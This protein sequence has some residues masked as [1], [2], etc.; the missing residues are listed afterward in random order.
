[1]KRISAFF[2]IIAIISSCN[3]KQEKAAQKGESL[4]QEYLLKGKEI[5]NLSQSEL[6]KNV[7]NAMKTGGPGHAVEFCNLRALSINDSLSRLHNCEIR[8]IATKYRN[9]EDMPQTKT[10]KD[11]LDEY[12]LAYQ[13]GDSIIPKVYHFDDRIEYYQPIFLSK[14]ACLLCHGVVGTQIAE[15]TLEEIQARYPNDLATGFA[16][17]EFRGAWKITF[18]KEIENQ[19]TKKPNVLF[20]AVDDLRPEL[21]FYG[22]S[23]IKSPNL[24]KLAASGVVFNKAYCNVPVCGASRS[25]LLTGI[26]PTYNRFLQYYAQAD[27]E[28]PNAITLP[29]HFKNNGYKTISVGKIFHT[30]MDN[31]GK[32]WSEMPYRFDHH[33]MPDGTWSDKGWQNYILEKNQKLSNE[34]GAGPAFEKGEVSDTAY[35]DGKY[36]TKAIEYLRQLKDDDQPFFMGLGF[37]KPHLPFNAPKR[38]WDMYDRDSIELADNPYFPESAPDNARFNWGELRAYHGIPKQGLLN[39][40]LSRTLAH[41]YYACVSATDALIGKVLNELDELGLRENTIVVLWGDHG[42][43]IGEHGMWCK[44]VNFETSLRTTL[45][46]SAPNYMTG[47]ANGI[48]ELVD[49][50]PTLTDLCAL[51]KLENQLQGQSLV[52]VLKDTNVSIK[53][54]AIS[55]W[56]K[57]VT[58][59]ED[60]YFYTEWHDQKKDEI[61]RMLY[62]HL[63]DP[64]EN[65]NIAELP[66]NASLVKELSAKLNQNLAADYWAPSEGEYN[67]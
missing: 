20:I 63:N 19:N 57:G 60:R 50:F 53:E 16:L 58:L 40:S 55:K 28:T 30:P 29:E 65:M 1:M 18:M 35:F 27:I 8:R 64:K 49:L 14:S 11:L 24:D 45:V 43:Q 25:S 21:N 22:A 44:H 5:V 9:P 7:S 26:R 36:A 10:E 13:Q 31:E 46:I 3:T 66:E 17:N 38:Y 56:M 67:R 39:D 33:K 32:A 15:E 23:H 62:D 59:V 48:V 61:G 34:T 12:Q 6:L 2:L 37:L 41:G 54:F 52:P 4:K 42:Y 51:P 47:K